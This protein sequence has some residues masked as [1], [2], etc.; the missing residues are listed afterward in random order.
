MLEANKSRWAENL[1]AVYNQNLLRRR[2]HSFQVSGLRLL[3]ENKKAPTII[4]ANHSSWWDGLIAFHIARRTKSDSFIM[5]EEKQLA[6]LFVFQK[7]GAFSVIRENSREA[8][9]SIDYAVKILSDKPSRNLWI[10]PQGEILPNDTRPLEFYNGLAYI[11][12]KIE[13]CRIINISIRYEFLGA[14]KPDIFVKIDESPPIDS[15]LKT[16]KKKSISK[17]LA[18]QLTANLDRLKTAIINNQTADYQ[19]II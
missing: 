18:E 3:L 6:D 5:M 4:Y 10:F 17:L 19:N 8:K 14:F 7:L 11:I 15:V 1:F 2:F 9:R 12:K 13:N 16:D